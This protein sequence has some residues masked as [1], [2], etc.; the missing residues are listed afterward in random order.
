M[1]SSVAQRWVGQSLASR[2]LTTLRGLSTLAYSCNSS[3]IERISVNSASS[4]PSAGQVSVKWLAAG[5]D[6]LDFSMPSKSNIGGNEGVG[7]VT[8]TGSGVQD[9]QTGDHVIPI[10][11]GLGTW[12]EE[13]K[14]VDVKDIMR[15]DTTNIKLE[16][17]GSLSGSTLTAKVLLDKY[18]SGLKDGDVILHTNA[19][20]AV[21]NSL[22]QLASGKH[23]VVSIVNDQ[24]MDLRD[25]TTTIERLKLLG[26]SI[27][28]GCDYVKGSKTIA[29]IIPQPKVIFH[30]SDSDYELDCIRK[31]LKLGSDC[32]IIS[33]T[34]SSGSYEQFS[35]GDWLAQTDRSVVEGKVAELVKLMEEDK[36]T[37]WLKRIPFQ[38]LDNF[39]ETEHTTRKLIAMM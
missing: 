26:S 16:L 10:K 27:A 1:I 38:Y 25:Y 8:N 37:G 36:L 32:K 39:V 2:G 19:N 7:V 30:G 28:V 9:V 15:I 33:Y 17:A 24:T 13:S 4:S 34:A 5:I 6:Q 11:M 29:S 22:V 21:G 20:D 14:Q 35:I 12:S 31:N 18:C 23:E 3:K